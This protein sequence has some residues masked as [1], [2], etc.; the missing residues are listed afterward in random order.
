MKRENEGQ[1]YTYAF[2]LLSPLAK[3]HYRDV[4]MHAV[5]FGGQERDLPA[6]REC[7]TCD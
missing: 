7:P 4:I 5:N 1:L 2:L 3:G 6:G